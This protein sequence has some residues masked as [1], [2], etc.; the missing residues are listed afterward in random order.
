MP[1]GLLEDRGE[2][3]ERSSHAAAR[4][5]LKIGGVGGPGSHQ[6]KYSNKDVAHQSINLTLT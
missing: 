4:D 2:G 1:A 5:D 3:F 6:H